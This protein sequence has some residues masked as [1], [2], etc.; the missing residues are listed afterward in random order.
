MPAL[1]N[2]S[3][4]AEVLLALFEGWSPNPSPYR[5]NARSQ[6]LRA[7]LLQAF[8]RRWLANLLLP[9][10]GVRLFPALMQAMCLFFI[11]P[12]AEPIAERMLS[13]ALPAA[14]LGR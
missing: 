3:G 9:G 6:L 4:F 11:H 1:L 7:D 13:S 12:K 2:A 8:L 10:L 5:Q 14:R